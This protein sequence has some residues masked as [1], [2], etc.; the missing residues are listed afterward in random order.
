M[1]EYFDEYRL[2]IEQEAIA[3]GIAGLENELAEMKA[4]MESK[5]REILERITQLKAQQMPK[6]TY[7]KHTVG[8]WLQRLPEPYQS[9]A[10]A[11]C[12]DGF[13]D[14]ENDEYPTAAGALAFAFRWR[15]TPKDQ[16]EDYWF[17]IH[18]KLGNGGFLLPEPAAP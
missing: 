18:N 6:A 12:N 2:K 15:C 11:N 8:W 10:F 1:K 4:E 17:E 16:G 14:I 13:C 5:A 7:R 3:Y 9:Q